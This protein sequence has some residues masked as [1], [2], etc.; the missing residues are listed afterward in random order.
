MAGHS[1]P[2]CGGA[3]GSA[4]AR[5]EGAYDVEGGGGRGR[6]V[7]GRDRLRLQLR[8]LWGWGW[9]M[10][11]EARRGV[12]AATAAPPRRPRPRQHPQI[13]HPSLSSL[14]VP[15]LTVPPCSHRAR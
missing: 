9:L 1:A 11:A 12:G 5:G 6:A 8:L 10:A 2:L 4:L 7:G 15:F 13:L 3:L 14:H